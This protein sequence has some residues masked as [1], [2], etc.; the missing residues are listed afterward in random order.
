LYDRWARPRTIENWACKT[1]YLFKYPFG[2]LLVPWKI[3]LIS[4]ILG[5]D[6]F[7]KCLPWRLD[8]VGKIV[9]LCVIMPIDS[10]VAIRSTTTSKSRKKMRLMQ[11]IDVIERSPQPKKAMPNPQN[12]GHHSLKNNC[13]IVAL[14]LVLHV[15]C[16]RAVLPC[17]THTING[18]NHAWPTSLLIHYHQPLC[19]LF[20]GSSLIF[21]TEDSDH[22]LGKSTHTLYCSIFANEKILVGVVSR[23]AIF[24]K[25][26]IRIH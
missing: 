21:W 5:R 23:D 9:A 20:V 22:D 8:V 6:G 1:P 24:M 15:P 19:I 7:H 14:S 10:E 16:L 13:K 4:L 18:P 12:V 26:D 17:P 2:M 3:Q 25:R 11:H